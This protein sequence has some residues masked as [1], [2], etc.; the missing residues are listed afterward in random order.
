MS[1]S[2][3]RKYVTVCPSKKRRYLVWH[4]KGP[5]T[6]AAQPEAHPHDHKKTKAARPSPLGARRRAAGSIEVTQTIIREPAGDDGR[7]NQ[8]VALRESVGFAA[9]CK[10]V[11][12][13]YLN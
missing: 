3:V 7:V 5:S 6:L 13:G 10:L 1:L 8:A 2:W 11:G 12:E 9:G 4:D